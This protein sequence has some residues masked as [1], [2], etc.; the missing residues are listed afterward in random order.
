MASS[1]TIIQHEVMATSPVTSDSQ[2]GIPRRSEQDIDRIFSTA[3]HIWE[4]SDVW[5]QIKEKLLS[6]RT[7]P[8]VTK[9]IAFACGTM[10]YSDEVPGSSYNSIFQH[11][12]L[13]SIQGLLQE[14]YE[15]PTIPCSM[16]DPAYTDADRAVLATY[17]VN[18]LDHP[19]GFHELDDNSLVFSCAP[20]FPVK[21]TVLDIARPAV[22]I[23]DRVGD[24]TGGGTDP[25][26]PRVRQI[27]ANLYDILEFP[28]E[29]HFGD[30]AIYVRRMPDAQLRATML[31]A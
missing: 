15:T 7:L 29:E 20:D 1:Y 21:M 31:A 10:S 26:S 14:R 6:I 9:I 11:A 8:D 5:V 17:R 30:M 12:F 13:V 4:A 27:M 24:G 2:P 19:S 22:I 18:V 16:Q 23:W 3:L 25:D 28:Y